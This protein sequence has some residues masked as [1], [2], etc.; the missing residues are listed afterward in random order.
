MYIRLAR[1]TNIFFFFWSIQIQRITRP[2]NKNKFLNTQTFR[3]IITY[4]NERCTY[5]SQRCTTIGMGG[6]REKRKENGGMKII[7]GHFLR[8]PRTR[9]WL[10]IETASRAYWIF[11]SMQHCMWCL[12]ELRGDIRSTR[13]NT[14]HA[15]GDY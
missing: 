12:M 4:M 13:I 9:H 10:I 1:T 7:F 6:A 14:Q 8:T 2:R 15:Y 5:R 11:A 3:T